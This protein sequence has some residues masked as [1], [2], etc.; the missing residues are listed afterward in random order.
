MKSAVLEVSQIALGLVY[1]FRKSIMPKPIHVMAFTFFALLSVYAISSLLP[2][3]G[4]FIELV[5]NHINL[6][7]IRF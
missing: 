4:E 6:E 3:I 2:I 7:A 5:K 1:F